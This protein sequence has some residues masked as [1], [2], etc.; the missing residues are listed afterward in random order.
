MT[1]TQPEDKALKIADA[2]CQELCNHYPDTNFDF[3]HSNP[4]D[5]SETYFN[6]P[7]LPC[8]PYADFTPVWFQEGKLLHSQA[9]SPY[10]WDN[11]SFALAAQGGESEGAIYQNFLFIHEDASVSAVSDDDGNTY[12][13]LR[14]PSVH[15]L[16]AAD[17]DDCLPI[18]LDDAFT[19]ADQDRREKLKSM[20]FQASRPDEGGLQIILLSCHPE[21]YSGFGSDGRS[22]IN[23]IS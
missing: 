17:H 14:P 13:L 12:R 2:V 8:D 21:N 6:F 20:L 23:F 4:E 10:F 22:Y 9:P 5:F 11:E 16:L 7:G 15:E 19:H 3:R 18:V 1:K